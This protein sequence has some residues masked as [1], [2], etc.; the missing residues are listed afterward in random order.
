MTKHYKL[1]RDK[2]PEIIQG[3]GDVCTHLALS[4]DVAFEKALSLKLREESEEFYDM[5]SLTELADVQEVV[6]AILQLRGV[7]KERFSEICEE[8]RNEYGGFEKRIFL[9][10][11]HQP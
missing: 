11:S 9:V 8:K 6:W 4:N 5:P 7:S 1:V 3:N 2:I 10:A